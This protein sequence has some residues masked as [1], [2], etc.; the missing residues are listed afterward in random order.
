MRDRQPETRRRQG[1]TTRIPLAGEM[2]PD[3]TLVS[4]TSEHVRVSDYRGRLNLILVLCGKGD[5]DKV[6]SLLGQISKQYS[7]FTAEEAQVLAVVEGAEVQAE[8]L[9]QDQNLPF[10]VLMD[11]QSHAHNLARV[12]TPGSGASP[13]VLVLDRFG[14]VRHVCRVEESASADTAAILDWVR[15]INSEC[16]ECGVP[17]WPT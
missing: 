11:P 12:L 8:H 9:K 10:P 6:R 2:A 17:E 5:S 14:E 7:E 1:Q 16:P 4:T 3:F 13:V 15:F